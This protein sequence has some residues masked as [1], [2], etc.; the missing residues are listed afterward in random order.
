M[1]A[2]GSSRFKSAVAANRHFGKMADN[3]IEFERQIANISRD[4]LTLQNGL[5]NQ[6]ATLALQFLQ[7][8]FDNYTNE[9][10]TIKVK[11]MLKPM[12]KIQQ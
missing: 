5:K 12:F 8:I 6:S 1:A 4:A 3:I 2:S 7:A 11:A 10:S 9:N